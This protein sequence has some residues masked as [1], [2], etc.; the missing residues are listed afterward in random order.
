MRKKY[1]G[2]VPL[3]HKSLGV[4]AADVAA[5][6]TKERGR[7]TLPLAFLM[8]PFNGMTIKLLGTSEDASFPAAGASEE[9]SN[10]R[11]LN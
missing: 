7:V 3:P 5:H 4:E 8:S 11:K 2:Y 10:L 6:A 9:G 1:V